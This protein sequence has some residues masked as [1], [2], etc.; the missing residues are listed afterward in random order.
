MAYLHPDTPKIGYD[1]DAKLGFV[2]LVWGLKEDRCDLL[3]VTTT[4]AK[5]DDYIT[6][7]EQTGD[8]RMVRKERAYVDH[9]FG[10]GWL[11]LA[12][13]RK[14]KPDADM[15]QIFADGDQTHRLRR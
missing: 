4:E 1:I 7:M 9:L 11:A 2:W 10:G 13:N 3:V 5:A 14:K 12:N 8:F 15:R 6:G